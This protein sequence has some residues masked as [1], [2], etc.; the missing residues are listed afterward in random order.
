MSVHILSIATASNIIYAKFVLSL[1]RSS[2]RSNVALIDPT[3]ETR[4][5]HQMSIGSYTSSGSGNS[6]SGENTPNTAATT[7]SE[8]PFTFDGVVNPRTQQSSFT[9]QQQPPPDYPQSA[10]VAR[11]YR[12][13]SATLPAMNGS[14]LYPIPEHPPTPSHTLPY[15]AT[16]PHYPYRSEHPPPSYPTYFPTPPSSVGPCLQETFEEDVEMTDNPLN[17]EFEKKMVRECLYFS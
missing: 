17:D 9:Q 7:V 10:P 16:P 14:T 11:V 1:F 12:S 6:I 5:Q 8:N 13:G 2:E 3:L 4:F 15:H